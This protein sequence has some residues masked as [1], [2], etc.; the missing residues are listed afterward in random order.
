[1]TKPSFKE[2]QR[3]Q[4]EHEIITCASALIQQLGIDHINLDTLAAEVGISKPTLY[5]HFSSKDE[6][7]TRVI[8]LGIE[9]LQG[10]LQPQVG[11]P[12]QRLEKV[13]RTLLQLNFKKDGLLASMGAD[14]I[15]TALHDPL[16]KSR[17]GQLMG[18]LVALVH[19]AQAQGDIPQ[20]M[21]AESVVYS[22]FALLSGVRRQFN[23]N[24]EAN[25]DATVETVVTLFL[26]G[27]AVP[28]TAQV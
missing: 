19:E 10:Y 15:M 3:Q 1:M 8:G 20:G 6:L 28:S 27:I 11:S 13:F 25:V 17:K 4:R 21:Q 26:H 12:L 23:E 16:N 14:A 2:R 5:Q 24:P 22:M 7:L 18:Q 9:A